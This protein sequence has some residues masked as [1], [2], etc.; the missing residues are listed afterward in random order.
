MPLAIWI[1]SLILSSI[2]ILMA[3]GLV[4]VFSIMG[5]LNFAHGQF[6]MVGAYILF[7]LSRL[8]WNNFFVDL[9]IAA[10]GVGLLG[11]LLERYVM[12]P[13]KQPIQ[14]IVITIA[15]ISV[16][17]GIITLAFSPAP[18]SLPAA[19]PGTS[20]IGDTIVS[21]ER[22]A[23]V[24]I[25][26]LLIIALYTFIQKTK[27]GLA[28]RAAAQQPTAA[29]L[30]GIRVARLSS[31]AMGLGCGLAAL[32]GGIMAPIFY[33]DPWMG[34]QPLVMALL[35]I[36]IGGMG[37]LGGAVIGGLILGI[38]GSIVAYYVGFWAQLLALC[39]VVAILLFRPQGLF[40]FSEKQP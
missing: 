23:V 20:T 38:T 30:F 19:F 26:V 22:I 8:V 9:V 24:V 5:I 4:L 15:L 7:C 14:V 3:S 28:L 10:V 32:A 39:L 21:N 33:I 12:R 37:S 31:L 2:Y 29:G 27:M 36:V 11:V 1:D 40:G 35:T 25:A 6:Y 13:I 34:A 18:R 16:F 17:E